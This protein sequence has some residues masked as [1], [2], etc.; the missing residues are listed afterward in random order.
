MCYFHIND[1]LA[2][3]GGVPSKERFESYYK[4]PGTLKNRYV[5]YVKTNLGKKTAWSKLENLI[6]TQN[7]VSIEQS[8]PI[9][10]W[11]KAVTIEL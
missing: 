6:K 11:G 4:E 3:K 9:I 7:F 10:D 2:E 1:L 8:S 5:R